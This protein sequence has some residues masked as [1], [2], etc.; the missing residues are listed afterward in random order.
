MSVNFNKTGVIKTSGNEINKN[1]CL[2]TTKDFGK[3]HTTYGIVDFNLSESLIEN[4]K[5]TITAKV[6]TSSEKKSVAF[7]LS[8]GSLQLS[9]WLVINNDKIYKATFTANS[10]HASNTAG[11]GHGYIRV[12]VSNNTTSQGSTT[13]T[14]TANVDWLKLEKGTLSTPWCMNENDWGYVGNNHGFIETRDTSEIMSVYEN[15]IQ[16]TEFIEY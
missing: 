8:G 4:Q 15:H 11:S 6:N 7:Y 12:Y 2:D 16:T 9:S 3:S 1:L 10:N 13:V 5:Y 14:G